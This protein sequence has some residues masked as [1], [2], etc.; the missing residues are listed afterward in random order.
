MILQRLTFCTRPDGQCTGAHPIPKLEQV[1][2]A[3]VVVGLA[4]ELGRNAFT[5]AR[6]VAHVV[7][8]DVR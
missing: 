7:G 1:L 4:V 8:E 6:V 5:K 2:A 3:K